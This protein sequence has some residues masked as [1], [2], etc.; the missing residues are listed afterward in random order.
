MEG[1]REWGKGREG[2]V[3]GACAQ[4]FN[5]MHQYLT[6]L[7]SVCASSQVSMASMT[8]TIMLCLY[9]LLTLTMMQPSR[10]WQQEVTRNES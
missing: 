3:V 4:C 1:G 2:Y 9:C 10:G 6:H 5:H 7:L 8:C